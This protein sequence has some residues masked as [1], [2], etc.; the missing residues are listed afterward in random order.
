MCNIFSLSKRRMLIAVEECVHG[1]V[2]KTNRTDG[3]F[4]VL[5]ADTTTIQVLLLHPLYFPG[6]MSFSYFD[7]VPQELAVGD[8][9]TILGSLEE[10]APALVKNLSLP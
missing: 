7:S 9:V 5:R 10:M 6:G 4:V 2:V 8:V 1:A 3:Y